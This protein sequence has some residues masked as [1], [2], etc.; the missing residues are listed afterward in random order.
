MYNSEQN[1]LMNKDCETKRLQDRYDPHPVF[2]FKQ[3]MHSK[4][5][6]TVYNVY[7]SKPAFKEKPNKTPQDTNTDL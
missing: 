1:K 6:P 4:G 7:S 5:H 3:L 2:V